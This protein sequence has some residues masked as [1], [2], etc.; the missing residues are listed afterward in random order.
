M[1]KNQIHAAAY[2][3]HAYTPLYENWRQPL[4]D[5][6]YV[7]AWEQKDGEAF[8]PFLQTVFGITSDGFAW[9]RPEAITCSCTQ[10]LAGRIP[11]I[12]TKAHADF[13]YL[14]ALLNGRQAAL[15]YPQTVNACMMQA[16]HPRINQH[17]ILLMNEAPYSNVAAEQLDLTAAE[18]QKRSTCLRLR[19]E[20]THYETLRLF[21][22]MRNHALDEIAADALGQMAAFGTFCAQR[23]RVL[24]GLQKETGQCEGRLTFYTQQVFPA[25][26]V[27]VYKA[28]D[29]R[30]EEVEVMLRQAVADGADEYRLLCLLTCRPLC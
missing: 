6:A 26:R 1:A 25:E 12:Q 2:L 5:E 9:V 20:C 17:R 15:P 21:G 22:G 13:C 16:H 10:T 8:L 29:A 4:P 14:A 18:W 11:V 23:Q 7:T 28:V 24:F 3:Q 30:L 27:Q 19:H